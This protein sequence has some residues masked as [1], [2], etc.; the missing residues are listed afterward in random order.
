[1]IIEMKSHQNAGGFNLK[2]KKTKLLSCKCCEAR[3]FK[4]RLDKIETKK[5]ILAA[6]QNVLPY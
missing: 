4:D 3:N 6:K 2:G 5:L 1:M